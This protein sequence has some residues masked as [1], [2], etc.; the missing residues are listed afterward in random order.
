MTEFYDWQDIRA[1]LDNGNAEALAA[2]DTHRGM[3]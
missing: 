1:E 2:A 3:G